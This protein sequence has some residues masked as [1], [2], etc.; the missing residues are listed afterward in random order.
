[1]IREF[2]PLLILPVN[3]IAVLLAGKSG[4]DV[5]G[6]F[7]AAISFVMFFPQT[8]RAWKFRK[9]PDYL[10]GVSVSAQS[11]ILANALSW[12]I[13]GFANDQFWPAAPGLVSIPVATLTIILVLRSRRM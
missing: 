8:V 10:R 12:F 2:A 5:A 3:L 13:F 1:M 7:G 4:G 9:N 11:F 6:F